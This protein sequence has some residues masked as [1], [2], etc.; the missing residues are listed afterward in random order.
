MTNETTQ[1]PQGT[2]TTEAAK[3]WAV[4][5][6]F[7]HARIAGAV[8]EATFGGDTFT[9]VDV[10]QVHYIE[11]NYVDG[12]RTP[13][14]RVIQAHT[15]LLG[16]KAVYSISFVDEAAALLAAH[17]IKHEP[18]R[19]WELREALDHLSLGD[20]RALLQA[21]EGSGDAPV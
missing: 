4:L 6:L 7:G 15:K 21:P 18:I 14:Q 8:S 20:R 17:R 2:T 19:A 10:P 11:E 3:T 13:Q 12:V 9:R 16:G 1:P 5:E